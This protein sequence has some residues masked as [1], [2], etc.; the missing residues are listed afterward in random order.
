MFAI[1]PGRPLREPPTN[2]LIKGAIYKEAYMASAT[3][4]IDHQLVRQWIES[5]EGRPAHV[6]RTA[7]GENPGELAIKFKHTQCQEVEELA[8]DKW[9]RW[10][11]RNRLALVVDSS[12]F[13][14]LV[15]R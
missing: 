8:W 14:K 2:T 7:R 4:L 10:F 12:G 6:M 15:P 5:H 1:V 13:N 11:E 3:P 9:L